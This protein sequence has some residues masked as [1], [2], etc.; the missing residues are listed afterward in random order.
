MDKRKNRSPFPGLGL[1]S[2]MLVFL[3][4]CFVSFA[5]LS[6]ASARSEYEAA[7]RMAEHKTQVFAAAGQAEALMARMEGV[8]QEQ[9]PAPGP[10]S[11]N[12]ALARALQEQSP[13]VPLF[14]EEQEE[15]LCLSFAIPAGEKQQLFLRLALEPEGLRPLV[16]R[17][18]PGAAWEGDDHIPV[19]QR[20]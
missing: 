13:D 14:W 10:W 19:I 17:L 16:W 2:L 8:L 15:T 11:E 3:V 9:A 1:S 6:L 20:E 7:R 18:Q 5:M 12:E 4:L